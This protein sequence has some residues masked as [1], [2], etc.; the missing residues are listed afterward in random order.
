MKKIKKLPIYIALLTFI[1]IS[2][3]FAGITFSKYFSDRNLGNQ[4]IE[5]NDFYFTLDILGDSDFHQH[6][7]KSYDLYGDSEKS[8]NFKVQNYYDSLRIT[9]ANFNYDV[10]VEVL[11]DSTYQPVL[12]S[13]STNNKSFVKDVKEA[14]S[15]TLTLPSG[16][17]NNTSVKV[18]VSSTLPYEKKLSITFNLFVHESAVTYKIE[19]TSGSPFASLLIY[20]NEDINKKDILIDWSSINLSSNVFQ[21]DMTN[22]YIVDGNKFET[23][24]VDSSIG[25]LVKAYN[26]LNI[27]QGEVIEILFFKA[28]SSINYSI[29]ETSSA[30][31]DGVFKIILTQN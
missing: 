6:T 11:N 21:I 27:K 7:Y 15:Y 19:D 26:T 23:N 12:T 28:D 29:S 10:K 20:C 17:N 13:S 14:E 3:T 2:I 18:V 4:Q 24:I 22:S 30:F 8:V 1:I 25:Y 5:A 31:E 16:F 9:K